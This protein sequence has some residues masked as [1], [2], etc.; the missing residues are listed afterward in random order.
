M[1]ERQPKY[2]TERESNKHWIRFNKQK[3]KIKSKYPEELFY[4]PAEY[5]KKE[6]YPLEH[7]RLYREYLKEMGDLIHKKEGWYQKFVWDTISESDKV[8]K[9]RE[10]RVMSKEKK[11]YY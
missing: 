7:Q 1:S 2:L 9:E 10:L 4:I 3:Q 8:L 11:Q 5:K 6:D